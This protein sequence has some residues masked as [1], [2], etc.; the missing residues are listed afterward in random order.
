M[1]PDATEPVWTDADVVEGLRT[2][3]VTVDEVV[4]GVSARTSL[5]CH[6]GCS[7]CCKDVPPPLSP[8][9]WK[10]I[11]ESLREMPSELR[12]R[13]LDRALELYGL[14][15][16]AIEAL[17]LEPGRFDDLARSTLSYVCPFLVEEACAIY[18]ARPHACRLYGNSFIP[19]QGKMYAC[20]LV[21]EALLDQDAALVNFEG[22]VS[23]LRLYP[24]TQAS[25]V[26]PWYVAHCLPEDL[27]SDE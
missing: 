20:H 19:S 9:E 7:Q 18:P 5:P 26:F 15:R 10:L 11:V 3:Y 6:R 24:D 2:F 4:S 25:Q 8:S 27:R 23:M 12:Q 17:Q 14:N 22:T 21:E 1:E 16:E 13:V